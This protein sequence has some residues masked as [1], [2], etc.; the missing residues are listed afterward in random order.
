MKKSDSIRVLVA[1]DHPLTRE[2]IV[3]VIDAQDD[4]RVVA[5]TGDGAA[6]VEAF[7]RERPDV[8]LM[9]LRMPRMSGLEATRRI[10]KDFPKARIIVLT[11]Y[12]GDE[13]IH[14]ALKAGALAYLLKDVSK[15]ELLLAIRTTNAGRRYIP[16][17]V[18]ARLAEHPPL[19]DLTPRELEV[20]RLIVRGKSNK[21]IAEELGIIEGT[22]KYHVS[23][24]LSKMGV[25]DRTGAATEAIRRGLVPFD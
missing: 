4:I 14:Q 2:G 9:D 23:L 18:S 13:F 8:V 19:S 7:V 17:N 3:T 16:Q 15:A 10:L 11:S 24:I 22:V 20:L 12:D 1:D 21:E 5:E 25:S 6:A